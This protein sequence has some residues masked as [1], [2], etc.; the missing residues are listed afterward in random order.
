MLEHL[1]GSKTRVKL[2]RILFRF[3]DRSFFVREMARTLEVQINAVRREIEILM[4]V[5]LLREVE[6]KKGPDEEIQAGAMLR[7]YYRLDKEA[8][9]YPELHALLVKEQLLGEEQFVKDLQS[10]IGTPEL[11]LLT[12]RFTHDDRAPSDILIVGSDI[13]DK[14]VA[15]LV[16]DYEKDFGFPIRYTIMDHQE[17]TDR[18]Y[19]MDKFLFSLFEA[20]HV[21]AVNVFDL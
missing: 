21:K 5:G 13:K 17:F 20:N 11:L 2:L 9:L 15:R 19:V 3:P 1:F 10:K 12:G 6:E 14:I 8:T 4:S 16:A 18:R 7:K